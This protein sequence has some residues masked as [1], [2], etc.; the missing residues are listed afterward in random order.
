MDTSYLPKRYRYNPPPK[1]TGRGFLLLL[2]IAII[3][4]DAAYMIDQHR[5]SHSNLAE[6]NT[7]QSAAPAQEAPKIELI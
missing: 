5:K 2:L 1:R 6:A 4:G 3:I 7:N